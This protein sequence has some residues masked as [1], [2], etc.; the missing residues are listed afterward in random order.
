MYDT[1]EKVESSGEND[2]ESHPYYNRNGHPN[3]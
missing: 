2:V 1:L 3:R